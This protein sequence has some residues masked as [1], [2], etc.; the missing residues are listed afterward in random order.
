MA[1][2]PKIQTQSALAAYRAGQLAD[3]RARLEAL[4]A[5]GG[6]DAEALALLGST[7]HRLDDE[8]AAEIALDRALQLDARNLR[9]V[10]AKADLLTAQG[11]AREANL[12]YSAVV[13]IGS[14]MGYL[15]G[16]LAR[17]LERAQA[18]QARL[19][20]ELAAGVEAAL[21]QAGYAPGASPSRF[22]HAL[23]IMLGRRQPYF[24]QP[25]AFYYPELPNIQF[26]PRDA[27]P[28][29]DAVE[30][31]TETMIGELDGL[32]RQDAAFQP[33]IRTRPGLPSRQDLPL[34][35]SM[36][37]SSSHL[38]KDGE[39]T[40]LAALCP[41]TIEAVSHAPL[42]QVKGRSPQVMFSRLKPGA[43]I[44]PHT[45]FVNTRLICH[46]PLIAPPGCRFRVGNEVREWEK[47]RAW[48]FD[49]TI[50]HEAINQ[51]DRDRVVLIFD[52]WRPEL[53]E[54]ERALVTT[55][56]QTVDAYR[57]DTRSWA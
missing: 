9:A 47:G 54:E 56:L 39:Q 55:L 15:S 30:A 12:F 28:W 37:W 21:A 40:E 5:A 44:T 41:R 23:D 20:E 11:R 24:Q 31:A 48:V 57:P 46:L 4:D 19:N 38:W 29:M 43:H 25:Q 8:A 3:A 45:G 1:L 49:D 33:Y 13:D 14:R 34:L 50:E 26:Y 32:L 51:S 10:L 7:C 16:E 36:D 53:S 18:V 17:G 27:F 6:A 2:D 35:D 42:C 52:I 22:A